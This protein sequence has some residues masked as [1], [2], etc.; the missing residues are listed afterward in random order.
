M[1]KILLALLV[2]TMSLNAFAAKP[3]GKISME[4]MEFFRRGDKFNL[5]LIYVLDS[6][7]LSSNRQILVTP[8]VEGAKGQAEAFPTV[9][10]NG[11]NMHYA[12][13]RGTVRENLNELY[14]IIT[15]VR[16]F[17]GKPQKMDYRAVIKFSDWMYDDNVTLSFRYDTCGCGRFVGKDFI[18]IP[19]DLNPVKKMMNSY[20]TPPVTEQ[21]IT[22]HEGEARVQF[23]VD[24]TELH[25]EPYRCKSGQLIDNRA[26]LAVI[27]DSIRYATTD[28]NVE[29]AGIQIIGYASPES[30]Y[31]HNEYLATNRSRA[32]AEYIGERFNLAPE[33]CTFGAVPENWEEFR[34]QVLKAEDITEQQR[35]DL[36]ELIDRPA[37]GPSDYDAKEK[38]LKTSNKFAQL[39]RSTI[40]PKWFPQLRATKFAISTKLKPLPDEQLAEVILR[41]PEQMTLNQMFRVA[42]LYSEDSPEFKR[43][44][45]IALEHYPDS[46]DANTNAAI[47]ALNAKDY[48]RAEKLLKRAGDSPEANNARGIVA[49]K[50]GDFEAAARYFDAAGK[51]PQAKHN[52]ALLPLEEEETNE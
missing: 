30:P 43:T 42:R 17:N 8:V 4:N 38:E 6:L 27:E 10:I 11:R 31:L 52:K 13:E 18:R 19:V 23:E 45:E 32:L 24:R 25:P 12:Y 39:Y 44:I 47:L 33:I 21:P 20:A 14:D 2:A 36:L 46:P 3:V 28:P 34:Q 49:T 15:E 41:N 9:L 29:I 26:Q 51:L 35:Q 48:E 5:Q 40:L 37:Y 7:R 22:I 1:K 16:R 50:R